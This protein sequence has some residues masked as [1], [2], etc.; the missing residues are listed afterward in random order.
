MKEEILP[1]K[2]EDIQSEDKLL[3]R[4]AVYEQEQDLLFALSTDI[5]KVR[6]K[7]DLIRL[8][9]SR[10]KNIFYFLHSTIA[11][12]DQQTKIFTPFLLDPD[13]CLVTDHPKYPQTAKMVYPVDAPVIR[14]IMH[15]DGPLTFLLD[16]I[17]NIPDLP[18]FIKLIHECHIK[19]MMIT[20]LRNQTETI[21]FILLYSNTTDSFTNNFKQILN[22][23]APQL[24]SAVSNIIVNEGNRKKEYESEVL[25]SLSREVATVK[26]RAHLLNIINNG[27]TPLIGFTNSAIAVRSDDELTYNFFLTDKKAPSENCSGVNETI[28]PSYPVNDCI[29]DLAFRAD[30]P[31]IF[32]IRSLDLN[33]APQWLKVNYAAGAREILIKALPDNGIS[34]HSLILFANQ[35]NSFNNTSIDIVE[36]IA[37]QLAKAANNITTNEAILSKERDKAHL[38][39]FSTDLAAVRT[40][41]DLETAIFQVLGRLIGVKLSMIRVIEDDGFL[42]SYIYDK[43][44]AYTDENIYKELLGKKLSVD[45]PLS[46]R[47]LGSYDPVIFNIEQEQKNGNNSPYINLWK[48]SGYKNMYGIRLRVGTENIG[49]LWLLINDI[50]FDLLKGLCSQISVAIF[51]IK[52]NEKLLAYKRQ[53]EVE[54]DHLKEQIKT[55]YNFSEIIGRG[56][57]MQ[58]VYRLMSRVAESGTTVLILGETGTGKELIARGI[59]NASARK[60]K[61]MI[62]VNCA[63][64]PPNLIESELFGHEKGSFTGAFDQRIGKFEMAHNSTLF[65][66]EIGELPVELQVKLLRVIQER[67]FERVGGKT[68]IK[69]NVRIIA[70]TNRN[71]EAEILAGKFRSDLYYRLNVFPINMPPLR[72]R[73]ED[74][75]LL[76]D[77][78]LAK[79]RKLT[80]YKVTSIAPKVLQQL[81]TYLW[82]G[83]VRELEHVIERSILLANDH[84]LHEVHLPKSGQV[85]NQTISFFNQTIEEMERNH[86]VGILK[87]CQGKISGA[88]GAA[89]V[90]DMQPTTLHSKIRKLNIT[91]PEYLQVS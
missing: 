8:F 27:L 31:S 86:I 49:T 89:G 4:I 58:K 3:K 53:L 16:E 18:P 50:N 36:S 2:I 5:T 22:G 83:N 80:G 59:H 11:L 6:E 29:Y 33:K 65:L 48:K 23:I 66:D 47:V 85:N 81:K 20:P 90:L 57:Q 34:K 69:V 63:A 68:T 25:L 12:I 9:S 37:G 74:I 76:V 61:L 84:I 55:I 75:G 72:E 54:N 44:T 67:E 87:Q 26:T 32:D 43:N 13:S 91:K 82:P 77:F 70:A 51:N 56:S 28:L 73:T 45:E 71:L 7:D 42:I 88:G 15:A 60:D 52:A 30:K 64:L 35:L 41:E 1:N 14:E 40:K 62:K 39:Q 19:E 24:S 21:G 38:L 17:I 79:Y 10:L 46:A 78:F